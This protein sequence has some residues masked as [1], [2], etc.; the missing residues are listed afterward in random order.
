MLTEPVRLSYCGSELV[1]D[2]ED[3]YTI[4]IE[5]GTHLIVAAGALA[6]SP[7]CHFT[8]P[9][10]ALSRKKICEFKH[11]RRDG[12]KFWTQRAAMTHYFV[13]PRYYVLLLPKKGHSYI[14][15]EI[16]GVRVN[17]NVS[18]GSGRRGWTDDLRTHVHIG[19]GHPAKLLKKLAEMAVRGTAYEAELN[20]TPL[21]AEDEIRW[22]AL[23]A[24]A[25]ERLKTEIYR[26]IEAGQRPTIQFKP[27][28]SYAGQTSGPAIAIDTRYVKPKRIL[29]VTVEMGGGK[30][31]V[32]L[33]QIDWGATAAVNNLQ[34]DAAPGR[35]A[36]DTPDAPVQNC[37]VSSDEPVDIVNAVAA[38]TETAQ[39]EVLAA[40]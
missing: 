36:P 2:E 40:A 25:S 26:R 10:I 24:K 8:H 35:G 34:I 38:R 4:A 31:Y 13:I 23:A 28:C 18:G 12:G 37:V 30:V 33:S 6:G 11:Y 17:L 19:V 21:T 32:K 5:E 14:P 22:A 27:R 15:A 39:V 9:N 7:A 16:N 1:L 3:G 20:G 29:G